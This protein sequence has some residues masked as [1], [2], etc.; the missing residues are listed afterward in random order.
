MSRVELLAKH[1][2]Q[3]KAISNHLAGQLV[4]DLNNDSRSDMFAPNS[5]AGDPEAKRAYA[6][7]SMKNA[8]RAA[9]NMGIDVVN[10]FTAHPS[11][12]CCTAFRR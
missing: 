4:C 9:A 12:T 10:G 6:I 8:A 3:V 1:G 2:L 7:E 11:G 5:C